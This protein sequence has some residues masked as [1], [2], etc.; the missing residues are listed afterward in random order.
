MHEKKIS[1]EMVGIGQIAT[2]LGVKVSTVYSWI[3]SRQI[4]Y[5][6]IGRLVKF[7]ISEINSWISARKVQVLEVD[8]L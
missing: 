7:K 3:H 8:T 1:E 6:K 2:H 5:Y 4:P